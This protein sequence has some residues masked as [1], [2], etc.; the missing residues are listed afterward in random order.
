VSALEIR[1]IE[2]HSEHSAI[3]IERLAVREDVLSLWAARESGN[4]T[5]RESPE[6]TMEVF[7]I[8]SSSENALKAGE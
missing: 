5:E 3:K 2:I 4:R 8:E 1:H 7:S 6:L